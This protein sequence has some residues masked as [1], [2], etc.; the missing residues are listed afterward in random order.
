MCGEG[1]GRT[2]AWVRG[3][4]DGT[5][6]VG[7]SQDSVRI[8]IKG[9]PAVFAILDRRCREFKF[10]RLVGF[11]I[12]Q[13][14]CSGHDS[15]ADRIAGSLSGGKLRVHQVCC[16]RRNFTLRRR[17]ERLKRVRQLTVCPPIGLERSGERP[18]CSD[19]FILARNR[20]PLAPIASPSKECPA[21][22]GR[23]IE[24]SSCRPRARG[25]R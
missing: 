24:A 22:L 16:L 12:G 10:C 21:E 9:T 6:L 25:Q 1:L 13:I 5:L 23:R 18:Q 7:A 11:F 4:R 20:D 15:V 14:A 8:Q 3:S 2:Y 19:G 17:T